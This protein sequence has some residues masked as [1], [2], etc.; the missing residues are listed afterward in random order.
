MRI[1]IGRNI[2]KYIKGKINRL[3]ISQDDFT[4]ISNNCWGTFIY[5]K[6][7]LPYQSPFIN[8]L[9]FA[10][11][12]IELLENFSPNILSKISFIEHKNTKHKD[13]MIKL[14]IYEKNY[15]IGILDNK[16][17]LHFLHYTSQEDARNKWLKRVQRM[18]FN[19]LIFKF[20]DGDKFEDS[21]AKRFDDLG[22]KNKVCFTAKKYDNL[23]SVV[24]LEK[25]KDSERGHDEWKNTKKEFNIIK[26]INNLEKDE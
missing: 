5:K 7:G 25:F 17:E 26:F 11:D 14:N 1:E 13:E 23:K 24:K 3:L 22:F 15:P 16:Y 10:P 19:N 6:F 4:I 9:I 12:Y 21:M 8:L 18:N 20:S 2:E